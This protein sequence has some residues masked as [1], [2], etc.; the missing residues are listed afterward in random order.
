MHVMI[1]NRDYEFPAGTKIIDMAREV[2]KDKY[3]KVLAATLDNRF[4]NLH[5]KVDRDCSIGFIDLS[6][7]NGERIYA[8]SLAFVLS[9]A[10]KD[11][12]PEG[13]LTVEHS[14]GN[15][16]YCEINNVRITETIASK[17]EAR[18]AEIVKQD[19]PLIPETVPVDEAIERFSKE[20]SREKA[21]IIGYSSKKSIDI[22][23]I[24]GYT[25]CL[26]GPLVP[27]TGYLKLFKLRCYLPGL[28]ILY[29]HGDSPDTIPPF[30]DLPKLAAVFKESENW[31]RIL[32]ISYAASLNRDIETGQAKDLVLISEALHEKKIAEIA[33]MISRNSE[34]T[35]LICIAGPSSSGKTS[36]SKRLSIQ[37]RVNG[38]RPLP[39]SLDN[40]YLPREL[41][42]RDANGEYDFESIEALDLNLF[43]ETMKSLIQGNE[44]RLPVFTFKSG[45]REFTDPI[46]IDENQPIIIEGIHGL[47]ERLTSS[48]PKNM[49]FKIYISALTQINI[50]ETNRIPT[51]YSRLIRRI[52]RDYKFRGASALETLKMWDEVRK[53]EE[54]NIFPYQEEADVM[55]NSSLPYEL[56]VLKRYAEPLLI[57]V[58][59]T[60][61][62]YSIASTLLNILSFFLPMDDE[63]FI[64]HN[65]ILREFIGGSCFDVY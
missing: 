59:D 32:N 36:F 49:K 10:V 64:P 42:P 5:Q 52:V 19:I 16:L 45:I 34:G 27:S 53:G 7:E 55:F 44:V 51:T 6:G 13:T 25:D 31:G 65:S 18:M 2:L 20:G 61:P 12:Y 35:R 26:Y 3:T 22:Y 40:F 1:E 4:V 63:S 56:P 30:R 37:L 54:K 28:L 60:V 38:L 23:S 14:L 47:N 43:N 17:L 29:P 46:R 39:I 58:P 57:S 33:D 9:K 50:D 15:G 24:D 21:E 11:L 8:R 41:C 62:E 48:I